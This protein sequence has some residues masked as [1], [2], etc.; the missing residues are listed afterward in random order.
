MRSLFAKIFL[1]F[2]LAITI[3]IAAMALVTWLYPYSVAPGGMLPDRLHDLQARG[4]L[5]VYE[6]KGQE[7][8]EEHRKQ[9]ESASRLKTYYL[10]DTGREL[11]GQK[12]PESLLTFAR[13]H[14]QELDE[15]RRVSAGQPSR[16]ALPMTGSD[17][18]KYLA[19]VERNRSL[20]VRGPVPGE[21]PVTTRSSDRS[22][23]SRSVGSGATGATSRPGA[24]PQWPDQY[25]RSTPEDRPESFRSR[26][27]DR[28]GWRGG[29]F[30]SGGSRGR[31]PPPPAPEQWPRFELL[32][33]AHV[34]LLRLLAGVLAAGLGCYMLA[35]YLTSPV[36]HL[37]NAARQLASGDFTTRVGK[38]L[39]ARRDEI[40]E[41]GREFNR[42]AGQVQSL[43]NTK[44]R[45]LRD[46]S[47]EL[48][49]PLSRLNV[50]LE[51]ASRDAGSA[52][53]PALARAGLE[54]SRLND[55]IGQLLALTRLEAGA[56]HPQQ[57]R[58]DLHEVVKQVVD[59]ANFESEAM[60]RRARIA[61]CDACTVTGDAGL[62]RSAI[63]NVVRNAVQHTG[64]GT[65]VDVSLR[66][67]FSGPESTAAIEVRDHGPGVPDEALQRI[68][69]PFYR[70]SDA[71]DRNSGG[72]GLGLAITER[73]I[74]VHGGAVS[75]R[76]AP[77]GGL[78]VQITLP[79][80]L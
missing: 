16:L 77:D 60:D 72:V 69:D 18:R 68:F 21:R 23:M 41:L 39:A 14:K 31:L 15:G 67:A 20:F 40:G 2:W 46:V 37:Q 19:L 25:A 33:P 28:G 32:V 58:V 65:T 27:F 12:V 48:R 3:V 50:A 73:A 13:D 57:A 70:V 55:L 63:E 76:N 64:A 44:Q 26:E 53:V 4:A 17:G 7:A 11:S 47:H 1:W 56:L 36:R 34:L 38:R 78:V 35:R 6:L 59:D 61:R 45:L 10:D 24:N 75:A 49:S 52:A 9:L 22:T 43:L 5:A 42:M 51:L 71:R 80:K 8:F 74:R 29:G 79:V 62:L 66:A 54:A 30:D